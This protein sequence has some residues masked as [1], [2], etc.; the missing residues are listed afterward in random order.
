MDYSPSS[1]STL[2]A[3]PD[4]KVERT[5]AGRHTCSS[6][7]FHTHVSSSNVAI[8]LDGVEKDFFCE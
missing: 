2:P 5:L 6:S 1:V 4:L 3:D 7:G 8:C